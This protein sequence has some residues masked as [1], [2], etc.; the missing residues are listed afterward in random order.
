M[1]SLFSPSAAE[2]LVLAVVGRTVDVGSGNLSFFFF[3]R[4]IVVDIL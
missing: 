3:V 1:F 4:C 2:P